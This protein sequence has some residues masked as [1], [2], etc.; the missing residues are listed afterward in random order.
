MQEHSS[1][2]DIFNSSVGVIFL[3]TP[4]RGT[5]AF[6]PQSALLAAIASESDLQIEMEPRVLAAMTSEGGGLLDV[7]DDFVNL[8][9]GT[10]L[11]ITCF[12]EQ[13]VSSLG[14]I[15]GRNDIQ[16]SIRNYSSVS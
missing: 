11:L 3:G 5:K 13:R 7:S 9:R 8:C 1:Y 14:R 12:F 6:G 15:V 16:V 2:P 4:H 10:S